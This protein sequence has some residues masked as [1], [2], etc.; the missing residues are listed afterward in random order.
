MF[1][2][3]VTNWSAEPVVFSKGTVVGS[4]DTVTVVDEDDNMWQEE[5]PGTVVVV[6]AT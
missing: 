6:N 2:I 1:N 3:L 5:S 4:V